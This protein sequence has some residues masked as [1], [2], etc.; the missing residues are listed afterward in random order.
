MPNNMKRFKLKIT[1]LH[2][3]A[4]YDKNETQERGAGSQSRIFFIRYSGCDLN[5]RHNIHY[6]DPRVNTG[7]KCI[8][9]CHNLVTKNM[10]GI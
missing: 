7:Q 10:F 2:H 4:F 5:N 1:I 3:T 9:V 6:L 8:H